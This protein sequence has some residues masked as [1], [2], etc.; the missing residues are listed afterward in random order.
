MLLPIIVDL[1]KT[2]RAI[3]IAVDIAAARIAENLKEFPSNSTVWISGLM[4]R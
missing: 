1:K 4:E 3:R 2:A